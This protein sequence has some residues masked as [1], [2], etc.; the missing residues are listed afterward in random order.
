MPGDHAERVVKGAWHLSPALGD[1]M[2]A[3]KVL[4]RPVFVRELLPRGFEAT[5]A[6]KPFGGAALFNLRKE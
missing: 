4:D 6:T 2:L 1:R 5:Y 3:A